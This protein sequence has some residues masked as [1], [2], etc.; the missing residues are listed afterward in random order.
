M[1]EFHLHGGRAVVASVLGALGEIDGLRPA[2]AGEFTR[3]AMEAGRLD[4]TQVE[5]IADLI[6][7]ETELQRR[8]AMRIASGSLSDYVKQMRGQAVTALALIEASI[9]FADEDD[10]PQTVEE[11]V[12]ALIAGICSNLK[13]L[14]DQGKS[15]E[16][17]R[18]G[19]RVA[20]VGAPNVG[21]S[22]LLNAIAGREA[23]I[24]SPVAGTTRD[25]IEVACDLDGLPVVFVD[26]AGVRETDDPVEAEGVR[27]ALEKANAADLRVF[28]GSEDTNREFEG[29][30]AR[31][32]DLHVW[33]KSDVAEN[34]AEMSLSA[35]TGEG[36]S[37]F[38]ESI[39]K[40]LGDI[41]LGSGVVSR[42]RQ[43][44]L[45]SDALVLLE[46]LDGSVASEIL[47][48]QIRLGLSL[49][50]EIL[51]AIETEELLDEIFSR[52]C[53]GK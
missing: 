37:D 46:R 19:F 27:R 3:R 23:A 22:T 11:E 7:A 18:D 1:V 17:V 52:F 53:M 14:V 13:L 44:H 4:L 48:E 33:T 16:R 2:E 8:L 24:T 32:I 30:E 36:V 20:L 43:T 41:A 42:S 38:L 45:L 10:A 34:Q 5:G 29:V 31:P 49:F 40:R 39:S 21:K 12:S 9:D 35:I 51:G 6:D 47:S 26:L 25:V 28:L 50:D 15:G